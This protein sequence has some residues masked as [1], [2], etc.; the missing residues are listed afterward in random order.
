[1]QC[2]QWTIEKKLIDDEDAYKESVNQ[3]CSSQK[4]CNVSNN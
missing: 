4:L 2:Y 1:M 3:L